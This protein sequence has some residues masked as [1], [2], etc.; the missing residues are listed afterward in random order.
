[1]SVTLRLKLFEAVVTPSILFGMSV[2][3]THQDMMNKIDVTRR[4]MLRR[5]VGWVRIPEEEW[6]V[7]MSRMSKRVTHALLQ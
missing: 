1:M 3:P 5:I 6:A 2:L 4:K 7:T